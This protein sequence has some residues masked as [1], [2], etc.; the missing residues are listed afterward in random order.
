[1]SK[2]SFKG[3]GADLFLSVNDAPTADTQDTL[4]TTDIKDTRSTQDTSDSLY[5][6]DTQIKKDKEYYRFNLKLDS[7]LKDYIQEA[8]W[9]SRMTISEYFNHLIKTDKVKRD[10][11]EV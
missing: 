5:T 11:G 1:M 4:D 6:L 10:K 9:L 8:A 3:T 7:E 2:K